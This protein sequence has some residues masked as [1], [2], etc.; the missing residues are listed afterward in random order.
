M[1]WIPRG[2]SLHWTTFSLRFSCLGF[3]LFAV[4]EVKAQSSE[5]LTVGLRA[6]EQ[7]LWQAADQSQ[8]G[9]DDYLMQAPGIKQRLVAMQFSRLRDSVHVLINLHIGMLYLKRHNPDSAMT[10]LDHAMRGRVSLMPKE[11]MRLYHEKAVLYN[12]IGKFDKGFSFARAFMVEARLH[13]KYDLE[14]KALA[15][16]GVTLGRFG[17]KDQVLDY[18]RQA[19]S[20]ARQQQNPKPFLYAYIHLIDLANR[21]AQYDTAV[22]Y[23]ALA[24]ELATKTNDRVFLND[25]LIN[26]AEVLFG[27]GNAKE[28]LRISFDLQ[29]STKWNVSPEA[30]LQHRYMAAKA[31]VKLGQIGR[32]IEYSRATFRTYAHA[33]SPA[34]RLD[35]LN[36]LATWARLNG[37][38]STAFEF[39]KEHNNLKDSILNVE[40][41]TKIV[42]LESQYRAS[43]RTRQNEKLKAQLLAEKNSRIIELLSLVV[44][45]ICAT[46]MVVI[47]IYRWHL[48]RKKAQAMALRLEANEL[49]R[50]I[51]TK[52]AQLVLIQNELLQQ[53]AQ[54]LEESLSYKQRE[55]AATTAFQIRKNQLLET[56]VQQTDASRRLP[57]ALREQLDKL[58]GF[59]NEDDGWGQFKRHFEEVHP[60]FF[61]KL[62]QITDELTLNDLRVASYIKMKIG[63][64]EIATLMSVTD[65]SLRNVR[66]RLR[67]KLRLADDQDLNAWIEGL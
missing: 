15:L 6:L 13:H 21:N 39:L 43:E 7:T 31:M 2:N 65:G 5:Q 30:I 19:L 67:K 25:V 63:H 9:S 55:L 14:S 59:M 38:A 12:Q 1:I 47:V 44:A 49:Q 3:L 35:W 48:S 37:D 58:K 41:Q 46:L 27:Q 52:A 61:V 50:S 51:D 20:V 18:Y 40:Q 24:K 11:R 10:Y 17:H 56:I 34:M 54:A 66:T 60:D 16:M 64:K 36:S 8:I 45:L 57:P 23:I 29:D 62:S 28:A 4:F 42:G 32:A 22:H 53:K 26:E 33:I